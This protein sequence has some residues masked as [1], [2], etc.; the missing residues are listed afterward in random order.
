MKDKKKN[1]TKKWKIVKRNKIHQESR[2]KTSRNNNVTADLD[3][4]SNND[5]KNRKG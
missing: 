1:E 2:R 5:Y 3:K 4:N